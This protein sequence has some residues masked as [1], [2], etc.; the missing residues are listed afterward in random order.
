MNI[1]TIQPFTNYLYEIVILKIM[2]LR[3]NY[4]YLTGILETLELC[5]KKQLH[6]YA[7]FNV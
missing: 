5:T 7:N 2:Q 6:K 3:V 4:L 1:E